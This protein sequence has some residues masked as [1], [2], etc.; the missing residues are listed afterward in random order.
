MI[1]HSD[2]AIVV[3]QDGMLRLVNH[4]AV[5]ITGYSEQELLSRLFVE[6]IHP[7]NRAMVMERY[8]KRLNGEESI[9]RYVFR[10]SPKDGNTRWVEISVASIDWDGRP[11]TLNFLTDITDR[12]RA[13]EALV[14]SE[15]QKTAILDGITTN[16][17]FVDKD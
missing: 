9:S 13:E 14:E 16:I 5:E 7:D 2:E 4:R 3:A 17:A 8:Q 6:F 10:L 12:K 15:T 11:A 1:E